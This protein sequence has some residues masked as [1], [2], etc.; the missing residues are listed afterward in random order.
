MCGETRSHGSEGAPA[1]QRAGATRQNRASAAASDEGAIDGGRLLWAI[2]LDR[3]SKH[4]RVG[5]DRQLI[6]VAVR[7][8][9]KRSPDASPPSERA[10][11]PC[12]RFGASLLLPHAVGQCRWQRR[13]ALLRAKRSSRL[14]PRSSPA[15]RPRARSSPTTPSSTRAPSSAPPASGARQT[16]K[17]YSPPQSADPEPQ[18][19]ACGCGHPIPAESRRGRARKYVS[20]T[21]RKRAQRRSAGH[22]LAG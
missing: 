19:C 16:A 15:P 9:N 1:R 11:A 2:G 21:H 14:A 17:R 6:V 20:E 13:T 10:P 3:D 8:L 4:S 7:P 12:V 22:S 18:L 5:G